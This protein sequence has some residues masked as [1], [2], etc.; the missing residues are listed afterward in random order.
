MQ[1]CAGFVKW[2]Y[3]EIRALKLLL[4]GERIDF[5]RKKTCF[6]WA[7]KMNMAKICSQKLQKKSEHH[8]KNL[9]NE[10]I[11][12]VDFKGTNNILNG[13]CRNQD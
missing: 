13:F 10:K 4:V 7:K 3:G 5:A 8:A 11:K 6:W 9:Q 2:K 12:S 1:A